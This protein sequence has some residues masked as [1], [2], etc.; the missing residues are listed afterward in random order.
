MA[1]EQAAGHTSPIS[2]YLLP[3]SLFT[4][5]QDNI[6]PE[7]SSHC[8]GHF[9]EETAGRHYPLSRTNACRSS[10]LPFIFHKKHGCLPLSSLYFLQTSIPPANGARAGR[11]FGSIQKNF[12]TDPKNILNRSKIP[13]I[14]SLCERRRSAACFQGFFLRWRLIHSNCPYS[15]ASDVQCS[16]MGV[17]SDSFGQVRTFHTA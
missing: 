10:R 3:S 14:A 8:Q 7:L 16:F 15:V 6:H 4:Q 9:L 1:L 12:W 13:N 11:N 17:I 5:G 2:T